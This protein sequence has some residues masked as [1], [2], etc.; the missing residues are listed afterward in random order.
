MINFNSIS[1]I[2]DQILHELE[3]DSTS[4]TFQELMVRTMV[5]YMEV[6]DE[7]S[8]DTDG[9]EYISS[10]NFK[11]EIGYFIDLAKDRYFKRNE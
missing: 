9:L 1:N 2:K 10:E 7:I 11:D 5:A 6:V 8:C 4:I 3:E